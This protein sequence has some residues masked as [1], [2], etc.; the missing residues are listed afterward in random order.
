MQSDRGAKLV[1]QFRE[2]TLT[3]GKAKAFV[4]E[5]SNPSDTLMIFA[6]LSGIN[7]TET[8]H[9]FKIHLSGKQR[10]YII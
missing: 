10:M 4:N 3:Q 1:D 7:G 2:V 8:A 6:N 5:Y 9:E